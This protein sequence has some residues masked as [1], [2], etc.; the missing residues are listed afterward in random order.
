MGHAMIE[1]LRWEVGAG[2]E[3]AVVPLADMV[4]NWNEYLEARDKR[5][6]A[7]LLLGVA[8]QDVSRALFEVDRGTRVTVADRWPHRS[9]A[10]PLA[11]YDTSE[12]CRGAS[13]VVT[14]DG[15]RRPRW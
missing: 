5:D 2:D 10:K 13:H 3:D 11:D 6:A 4:F 14:R 12:S 1:R 8:R 9:P 7:M 15:A